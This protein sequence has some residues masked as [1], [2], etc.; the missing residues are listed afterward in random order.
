MAKPKVR[1]VPISKLILD[2]A[3]PNKHTKRGKKA[4]ESS[5]KK[6]GAGRS[7]LVDKHNRVIAGN[8]TVEQARAAGMKSIAVIEGD[9]S[10][11]VAHQRNDLDLKKDKAARELSVADNRV[12][13]LD[14]D[15]DAEVLS[16]MNI[17]L[18]GL[19]N[20]G[21]LRKA[22]GEFAPDLPEAPEPKID[23]AAKLQKKWKTALGQIWQIG[24]HRLLVGDAILPENVGTLM[25]GKRAT[26]SFT[27]PP[28]N[29]AIG[30]DSNPRHRQREGLQNDNMTDEDFRGMIGKVASALRSTVAGDIYVVLGCEQWPMLD[31]VLREAGYHW[32][33]TIIWVKDIFVLGR[34]KY[35]RRYEPIWYGWH[36]K[37][38]S[39]FCDARDLDDVWE[40][41]RPRVSEEHPTMKPVDLV[42]HAIRNSSTQDDIVFDP[43]LGSGTTM[44]AAQILERACYGMDIE[45]KYAAVTIERLSEMGLKPRLLKP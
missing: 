9:G 16:K 32:S 28:W 30:L 22:M 12:A 38:K 18:S 40:I 4:L 25:H 23:Q 39:S 6:Y 20:E 3:N 8:A 41:A 5:L 27:D 42:A 36:S 29:V 13:E 34:S 7:V 26:M 21:E 31:G 1:I 37:G 43:F 11:L 35:H 45:P 14:L 33:A 19:F 10:L 17:D 2:D 24:K 44:C 15:W